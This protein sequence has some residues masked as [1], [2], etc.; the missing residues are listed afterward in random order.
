VSLIDALIITGLGMSVVFIGLTLTSLLI[1]SFSAV[2][3]FFQ[4][5]RRPAAPTPAAVE[6]VVDAAPLDPQV[7]AVIL[8]VLEIELR[9]TA[10][11]RGGRLTLP[12][13][14][15]SVPSSLPRGIFN[16]T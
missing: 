11:D 9:L 16:P 3:A 14:R 10:P 1:W 6:T 5:R 15:Q 7:L 8:T 13:Q 12:R 4:R 2:P